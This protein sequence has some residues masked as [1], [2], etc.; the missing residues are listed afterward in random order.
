MNLTETVDRQRVRLDKVIKQKYT[1]LSLDYVQIQ[2]D[3]DLIENIKTHKQTQ[4]AVFK[5]VEKEF[6][7]INIVAAQK[8][9]NLMELIND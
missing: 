5:V 9:K 8:N 3:I 6:K 1:Q 2:D 4:N 7:G